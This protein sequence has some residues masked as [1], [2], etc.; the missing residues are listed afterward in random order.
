M[1][2]RFIHTADIHLDSPLRT[3]ALKDPDIAE[4]VS[5]ATRETFVR[6]IDLCINEEVDALLIAGDLFDG[7]LHSVKTAAFFSKEMRR[8]TEAQINAYILRGN[9]DALSKLTRHLQLP[10]GVF[11]F[12]GKPRSFKMKEKNAVLHGLSFAKPKVPDSLVSKYPAPVEGAINIGLLHT[13][14]AG[15]GAHDTYSPC[16]VDDLET[17]GYDYWALGHIHKRE[18]ING[19]SGTIVMPGIPQG[20]HINEAGPKSVTLVDISDAHEV[21]TQE[22][23]LAVTQFERLNLDLT[24]IVEWDKMIERVREAI[25][26]TQHNVT[27]EHLILRI[28]LTGET[29]LSARMHRDLDLLEEELRQVA[30]Q[31]GAVHCEKIIVHTRRPRIAENTAATASYRVAD[32]LQELQKIALEAKTRQHVSDQGFT[33]LLKD[34]MRKLPP[35]LRDSFDTD[36][37]MDDK[38][39]TLLFENGLETM[40]ARLDEQG[41]LN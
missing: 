29:A 24:G 7:E 12:P 39:L 15:S 40:L 28:E 14:L 20:R 36:A 38:A 41:D 26:A 22:H 17:L 37:L 2:F 8:L 6:I 35:E 31:C 4:L 11:V 30:S 13:S 3:L 10:D 25:S 27:A 16:S 1:S 34:L 18:V 23:F 19:A 5:N 9:H 32:P 21:Q 33:Q